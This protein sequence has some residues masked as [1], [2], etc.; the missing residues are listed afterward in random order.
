MPPAGNNDV[1]FNDDDVEFNIG[2][3]RI[4]WDDD[5]K[6]LV[7]LE[8]DDNKI[9]MT[10]D[11]DVI[12]LDPD[13]MQVE[14]KPIIPLS[15][16]VVMLLPEENMT[17]II[18]TR[19][20]VKR[21]QPFPTVQINKTKNE[22][23][24]SVRD[25]PNEGELVVALPPKTEEISN[26]DIIQ[27][28]IFR[29]LQKNKNQAD[30]ITRQIMNKQPITINTDLL[31]LMPPAPSGPPASVDISTMRQMPWL[32]FATILDNTELHLREQ[33]IL[34]ILQNNFP[35]NSGDDLYY[36]HHDPENNVFSIKID[37]IAEEIQ[38]FI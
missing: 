12:L 11:R 19:N 28:P 4:V 22:T 1:T 8:F 14:D 20:I 35:R 13:N 31:A 9:I 37:E 6:D 15:D 10:D 16:E 25:M 2:D 21:K 29:R 34:D 26:A 3:S 36:I 38:V 27:H 5:N 33:V 24:I 30:R 17:D 32:D 7:P 23:D 18:S